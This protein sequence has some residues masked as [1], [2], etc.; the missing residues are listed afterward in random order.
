[1]NGAIKARL[2]LAQA[3]LRAFWRAMLPW[4]L[5]RLHQPSTYVGLVV[6]VGGLFGLVLTDSA[7]GQV[8]EVIAVVMGAGLVAWDSTAGQRPD[9]S[10]KAGA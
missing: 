8:A 10:D 7:A 1:M 3:R 5:V 4:I 2:A 6:K 9:E